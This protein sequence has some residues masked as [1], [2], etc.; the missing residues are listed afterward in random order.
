MSRDANNHFN[1]QQIF[2]QIQNPDPDDDRRYHKTSEPHSFTHDA[3]GLS[4]EPFVMTA[5]ASNDI[6][7]VSKE[8][9]LLVRLVA[10]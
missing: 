5:L 4:K 3:H 6:Q 9:L 7:A 2:R 1:F 8:A 10:S